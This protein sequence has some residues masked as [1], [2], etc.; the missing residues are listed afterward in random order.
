M[1]RFVL[2][3]ASHTAIKRSRKLR[4]KYLSL[5]RRIGRNRAKVAITRILAELIFTMLKNSSEFVDKID[6]LTERKMKSMSQ[7][8]MNAKV[9]DS[10]T[11]SVK[12]I[13]EKLFTK[14]SEY[15]FS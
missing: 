5:V 2:V 15:P 6:S 8:A 7:K 3:T 13:R 10:I 1:L 9:S 14:S 4:A 11:H 12:I